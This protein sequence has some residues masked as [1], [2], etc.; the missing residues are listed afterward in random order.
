MPSQIRIFV[1]DDSVVFRKLM[2]T[3]IN[4][5]PGVRT[6][7]VASNGKEAIDTIPSV[8]P[9]LITLDLNMPIMD[10]LETLRELRE[11]YPQFRVIVVSAHTNEGAQTTLKAL[12]AGALDVITKP[13]SNDMDLNSKLLHDQFVSL[14]TKYSDSEKNL[15]LTSRVATVKPA[16]VKETA[17]GTQHLS[18]SVR[19]EII[20][21]GLSTGGPSALTELLPSLPADFSLPVL[22]VQH[23]PK[24]FTKTLAESLERKTTIKVVEAQDGEVLKAA[25]VYI[26]PGGTQMKVRKGD[27]GEVFVQITDEPAENFCK[28]SADYLF[29]SV[30]HVYGDKALGVIMT[31]MG[32]DGVLGLRLMKRQGAQVIAQDRQSC[33]VWGMPRMAFEAGVVDIVLPLQEIAA[34]IIRCAGGGK[35]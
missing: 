20:A 8:Q 1:V 12:E 9:D 14:L 34:E 6:V 24:L 26:A 10:G 19:P 2:L 17:T 27:K 11:V 18:F 15:D 25:T 28:P 21:I 7:G 31:G 13:D 30:A 16:P 35:G 3:T 22:I 5:I 33:T 4:G 23:M 32:S 29:R